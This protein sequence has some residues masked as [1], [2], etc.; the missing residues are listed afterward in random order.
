[1]DN[2][3]FQ[4]LKRD[5][6]WWQILVWRFDSDSTSPMLT[7][8]QMITISGIIGVTVFQTSGTVLDIAGPGGVLT[9]FAYIGCI[10]IFVMEGLSKMVVLWPVSNAMVEFV[11]RF[12][13]KDLSIVIGVAYW[14]K[15]LD[16][17]SIGNYEADS[18]RYTYSSIFAT[19]IIEASSLCDF[20]GLPQVWQT[21]GLYFFCPLVLLGINLCGVKVLSSPKPQQNDSKRE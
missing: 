20:W 11:K 21:L 6:Q 10:A 9:A 7:L 13:D 4:I 17:C 5:L 16:L 12:V 18:N 14:S 1:M 19:L 8:M 15:P 2:P 3:P